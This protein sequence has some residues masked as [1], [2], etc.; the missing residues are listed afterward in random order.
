MRDDLGSIFTSFSRCV[1]GD[2][3]STSLGKARVR[4]W[5]RLLKNYFSVLE[6]KY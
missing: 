5:L 6:T 4:L 3:C 1:V 2:Q